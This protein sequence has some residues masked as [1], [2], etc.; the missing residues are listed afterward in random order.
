MLAG[1]GAGPV[2]TMR[3]GTSLQSRRSKGTGG[4]GTG[5]GVGDRDPSLRGSPQAP[6]R[7]PTYDA[8][9]HSVRPRS[10]S[11][12]DNTTPSSPSL[13]YHPGYVTPGDVV[14]SSGYQSTE[15]TERVSDVSCQSYE[16]LLWSGFMVMFCLVMDMIQSCRTQVVCIIQQACS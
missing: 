10:S 15:E 7:R 16:G 11:T 5:A 9:Q 6:Q 2:G 3:R 4:N 12:T 13:G 14:L 8:Q 1:Q